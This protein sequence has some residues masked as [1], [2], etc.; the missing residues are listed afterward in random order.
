[1]IK[2]TPADLA[3]TYRDPVSWAILAVDLFPIVAIFQ[4]GWGAA[5]V[6]FLY[7]LE[8]LILGL[9]A[10]FRMGAT[11][12]VNGVSGLT[13]FVFLGAFFA[14]HY[15]MF[16]FVHG[17]FL[18]VFAA[19]STDGE[20]GGINPISL[21]DYA[22]S[23]GAGMIWFVAAIAGLQGFLFIRD[24]LMRGEFR[25]TDVMAQMA[26]PYERVI[27]LHFALFAG[28]GLLVFLG[29]PL[30]GVLALILLR[31]GW[32]VVQSVR[33]QWEIADEP[34]AKVDEASPI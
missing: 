32:G 5:A 4:F 24:F 21:I 29:E 30:I 23:T 25:E 7:W 13:G 8:N 14:F 1:M 15:G 33:R 17:V 18:M 34:I 27:V 2:L 9:V 20:M 19:I 11:S 3:R 16:C 26:E 28:A 22:F 12:S 10:I 6:V 31:A